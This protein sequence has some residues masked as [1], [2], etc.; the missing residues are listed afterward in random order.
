MVGVSKRHIP[1]L[2]AV[3]AA[4]VLGVVVKT[5]QRG[6]VAEKGTLV[7]AQKPD[8]VRISVDY[9]PDRDAAYDK[10]L[11]R[12]KREAERAAESGAESAVE[13]SVE[14]DT[15]ASQAD[16]NVKRI[17]LHKVVEGEDQYWMLD[18]PL[19]C[20]VDP[21]TS[22]GLVGRLSMLK[23]ERLVEREK[24]EQLDPSEYGLD[25]PV[26]RVTIETGKGKT[27]TLDIGRKHPTSTSERYARIDGSEAV[28]VIAGSLLSDL[29]REAK[30]I[31]DK[32]LFTLQSSEV[33][34][35]EAGRS[36]EPGGEAGESAEP[37][38]APPWE[39]P[40][41]KKTPARDSYRLA[42]TE[43]AKG[44][45]K[46]ELSGSVTAEA[47]ANECS[48]LLSSLTA[49][50]ADEVIVEKPNEA[51][52]VRYGLKE[53]AHS[54]TLTGRKKHT[55]TKKDW[56]TDTTETLWIGN[57]TPDGGKYYALV[58]WRPEIV[59]I[60]AEGF[61]A[62]STSAADLRKKALH[63]I[64]QADLVSIRTVRGGFEAKLDYD[65]KEKE[66]KLAGGQKTKEFAVTGLVS[67]LANLTVAQYV[68]DE[69]GDLATYG[70]DQP[71][72]TVTLTPKKGEPVTIYF[73]KPAT[74]SPTQVYAK[75]ADRNQV[76]GIDSYRLNAIPE[77]LSEIADV[78]AAPEPEVESAAPAESAPGATQ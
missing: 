52:L 69:P 40:D 57:K 3:A 20:R 32:R 47:D 74:N 38:S 51:D 72:A 78:P 63:D 35:V 23:S 17:V 62:V 76:V 45:P 50:R 68:T 7:D 22:D 31:R 28:A 16:A 66:W 11:E 6:A 65:R 4:V 44:D 24:G 34:V 29:T 73:G 48:M 43:T 70:L 56:R 25:R 67:G 21:T 1:V 71:V 9:W 58:S 30:E 5:T 26:A 53:A 12:L 61:E 59:T 54:Y 14:S 55:D 13:S 33:R 49:K 2:V 15:P 46:W 10:S 39:S 64:A 27:L 75:R 18:E 42:K 37:E 19:H 60:A 41:S 77:K 36:R 8:L